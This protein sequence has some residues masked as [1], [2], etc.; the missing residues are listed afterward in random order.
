[1]DSPMSIYLQVENQGNLVRSLKSQKAE[2]DQVKEEIA[3]LLGLKKIYRE[4]I[5]QDYIAGKPPNINCSV[6]GNADS[7]A[8]GFSAAEV[9]SQEELFI[10]IQQQGDLVRQLKTKNKNSVDFVLCFVC[11]FFPKFLFLYFFFSFYILYIKIFVEK[12]KFL[13]TISFDQ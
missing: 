5:G 13:W 10:E 9:K 2:S 6:G 7:E 8:I 4:T 12:L 1:M 11:T 3:K